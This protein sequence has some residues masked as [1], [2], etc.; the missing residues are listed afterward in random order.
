MA[1]V[2]PSP[3]SPVFH[4]LVGQWVPR[5]SGPCSGDAGG[6]SV[7]DSWWEPSFSLSHNSSPF[8]VIG[9]RHL[10][11]CV[12]KFCNNSIIT[13]HIWLVPGQVCFL[14]GSAVSIQAASPGRPGSVSRSSQQLPPGGGRVIYIDMAVAMVDDADRTIWRGSACVCKHGG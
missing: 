12:V 5:F 14:S 4:T 6:V 2:P 10:C 7:S 1:A 11:C 13:L 8:A 3:S 9:P